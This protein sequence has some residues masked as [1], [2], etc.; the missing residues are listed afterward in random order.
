MH[1][2]VPRA[3]GWLIAQ[4]TRR[5]SQTDGKRRDDATDVVRA[6]TFVRLGLECLELLE[7]EPLEHGLAFG[8]R[9]V[10]AGRAYDQARGDVG[11]DAHA[12]FRVRDVFG[13]AS[14]GELDH[15]RTVTRGVLAQ[16]ARGLR[17]V[18]RAGG[19]EILHGEA[20]FEL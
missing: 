8:F 16:V 11:V 18:L 13:A 15:V 19:A 12:V 17:V 7:I 2:V 1:A 14:V 4:S 10:D 5:L 3:N 6:I 20:G 9:A